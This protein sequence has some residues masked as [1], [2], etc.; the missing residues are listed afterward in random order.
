VEGIGILVTVMLAAGSVGYVA[1]GLMKSGMRI[2]DEDDLRIAHEVRR[3]EEIRIAAELDAAHRWL[4]RLHTPKVDATGA[5]LSLVTR[6]QIFQA[7][8]AKLL[9]KV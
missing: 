6:I 4:D 2:Y 5:K 8:A 3:C 9:T 7:K 1:G